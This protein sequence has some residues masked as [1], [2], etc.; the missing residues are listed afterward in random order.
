MLSLA[1]LVF[2]IVSLASLGR[3]FGIFP[4]ARRLVTH[5]PYRWVRHPLYLAEITGAL[6]GLLSSISIPTVAPFAVFV[7]LQYWRA[8]YE[9]RALVQAF[10]EYAEYARKTWRILP[11]IH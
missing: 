11:G 7:V 8:M 5:G 3:S 10:P 2:A 1:G 6:G 4:E 9:E